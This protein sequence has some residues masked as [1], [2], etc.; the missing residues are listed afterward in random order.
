MTDAGVDREAVSELMARRR[1]ANEERKLTGTERIDI[2]LEGVGN[3]PFRASKKDWE[4]IV[5]EPPERGGTDA[6]PNP[7]AY[8]LSGAVSCLLSHCMLSAIEEGVSIESVDVTARMRYNRAAEVSRITEAI[9]AVRVES[10]ADPEALADLFRRAQ[11]MC[12]AHNTLGAAGVALRT[13]V[14][15]NGKALVTLEV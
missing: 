13:E 12:Y 5:D 3:G 14:E 6:A 9:Y 8:F 11:A 15:L 7:L 10:E 2:E 1:E 4:W